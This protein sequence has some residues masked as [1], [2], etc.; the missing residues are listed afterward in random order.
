[1]RPTRSSATVAPILRRDLYSKE[2]FQRIIEDAKPTD[3]PPTATKVA[4]ALRT[5]LLANGVY[6]IEAEPNL[7][8][9]EAVLRGETGETPASVP[10]TGR[11]VIVTDDRVHS[12]SSQTYP[13]STVAFQ[14]TGCTATKVGR[15]TM[16]TAAHCIY[17]NSVDDFKCQN[18]GT[19][20]GGNCGGTYPNWRFGVENGTGFG[21]FFGATCGW[22]A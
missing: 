21:A 14:E 11:T 16:V 8:L 19:V 1:M 3:G 12:T 4:A 22:W 6:Y 5:H 15:Y 10:R 17:D 9:G 7:E 13:M 20:A 18:G 2:E